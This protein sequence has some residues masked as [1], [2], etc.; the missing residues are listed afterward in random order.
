MGGPMWLHLRAEARRRWPAWLAVVVLIGTVGGLVMGTVAG[1]RRTATAFDRMVE[2]T[3]TTEVL[4]NPN[5]GMWSELDPAD[6]AELPGVVRTGIIDG[7]GGIIVDDEGEFD[8]ATQVFVQRDPGMMVDFERPRVVDGRL[9]DPHDPSGLIITD[10]V[11]DRHDV[12]VGD[13]LTIGTLTMEQLE[14]WEASGE[15]E[16]PLTL[17][18]QR[19]DGVVVSTDG[20][21]TDEVYQYGQVVLPYAF[22]V[23]HEP[24]SYYYGIAVDLEGGPAAVPAFQEALRALVPDEQ[25]ELKTLAAVEDTVDRGVRPHVIALV[26]FVV[27]IGLAGTV[28]AGQ[29]V[30]RQLLPLL[31]ESRTLRAVGAGRRDV[32][33]AV[34]MRNLV[35]AVPG[36]VLAVV[37]AIAVSPLF[38]VGVARRAE[39]DPGLAVD[40]GVLVP[41]VVVLVAALLVWPAATMRRLRRAELRSDR[42]PALLERLARS[43]D[44][45][46]VATGLRAALSPAAGRSEASPRGALAGLAVAVGAVATALTFGAGL[47]HLVERPAA[48]GWA[49]D[50][51]VAP[52]G[53][54]DYGPMVSERIDAAPEFVGSMELTVD[55]LRIEAERVPAVGMP[56]GEDGPAPTIAAGRLPADGDEI[57]LGGRTMDRLG[58]GI[59]DRVRVGEP[60]RIR[61]LTVVGQ[62]VF[63][64]LG[65]YS[66]ADRTELGKGALLDHDT[67]EQLGEGFEASFIGIR[68]R[69][70]AALD[71]GLARVTDGFEDAL[72]EGELEILD[73]PQRPSD[74][75][76]LESVRR[77][78]EIIAAVL[79]ALA[80]AALSFVLVAGVRGRRRELMLLRTF[81]F[82]RRQLAGTVVC[83]S[84][85]T[86]GL[87]L[88]IG[89]PLGIVVGRL[90]WTA[91]AE[92]LGVVAEPRVP[93][94][95]LPVAGGVLVLAIL[96]AVVP[97]AMAARSRPGTALR[98]E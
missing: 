78:P 61:S 77:T 60:D 50:A 64:G 91:L 5:G 62:A 57:A 66:G 46:V 76:S 54:E 13:T 38:P 20:I 72:E 56:T 33:Q 93:W 15:G 2:E 79:A 22:S 94:S 75:R 81:G 30:T 10:D 18:Q 63:P 11:A 26:A 34:L 89:M 45:P 39:V 40:L 95:L 43:T 27:L 87:A 98:A 51:M 41:G 32:R 44:R 25:F 90:S 8:G 35:L 84:A 48:Y 73:E 14:A 83:Q 16:P 71:A 58:V 31:G 49:W 74:V 4:V 86:A 69:D 37:V 21:V 9:F 97:A 68:A 19:V 80:G 3:E 36:A 65:T 53:D 23:E 55:Q 59:G 70:R 52:P 17:H 29:A 67:L 85:I 24:A 12:G 96:V 1:A 88:V 92:S 82:R 7:G 42:S 6:V 47:L 28:V